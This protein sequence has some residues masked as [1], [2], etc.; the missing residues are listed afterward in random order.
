MLSGNATIFGI[1]PKEVGDVPLHNLGTMGLTAD[2]RIFR[3]VKAGATL[4]A[5]E[6]QQSPAEVTGNQSVIV[7]AAAIGATTVTTTDTVT[8][9]ANQL[10]EGWVLSTKEASTGEGYAYRIKSHPAAAGAVLTLELHEPLIVAFT[11]TTQVDLVQNPYNLIIQDPTDTPSSSIVG[12]AT[13]VMTTGQYGWIQSGGPGTV[14]AQE[15][16]T[17]GAMCVSSN[18]VA[19][20]V[21]EGVDATDAQAIVG[22]AMTGIADA[23][24]GMVNFT[25]DRP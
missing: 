17:V 1:K 15:A 3:Y 25:I 21:E 9:T 10:A 18:T 6:L 23:E 13:A 24:F 14:L 16:I 20:A 11:A 2:G 8:V 22:V 5:G 7:A 12:V 19:G 4:V